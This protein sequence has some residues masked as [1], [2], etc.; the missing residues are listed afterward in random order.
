MIAPRIEMYSQ[1]PALEF[2][3]SVSGQDA[4]LVTLGYKSY[5]QL[6]YGKARNYEN[7]NLKDEKWPVNGDIDK[8]VYIAAKSYKTREF[9]SEYPDLVLLY[10]KNGFA[11]FK[12]I[13]KSYP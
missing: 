8:P 6:F 10:E 5:A 9:L 4:Y 1:R 11:F 7:P 2:F 12:R 3:E 13:P